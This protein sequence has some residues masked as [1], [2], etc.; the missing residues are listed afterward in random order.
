MGWS[1]DNWFI[2]CLLLECV[3]RYET[4]KCM[5]TRNAPCISFNHSLNPCHKLWN[6][7]KYCTLSCLERLFVGESELLR[8]EDDN[9]T[10]KKPHKIH[11]QHPK[12]PK[13]TTPKP[14]RPNGPFFPSF[15]FPPNTSSLPYYH[16][17]SCTHPAASPRRQSQKRLVVL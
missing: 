9:N 3:H 11:R 2:L 14:R 4:F 15:L 5:Y 10:H 13:K 16:C 8:K 17:P 6:S 7:C 1:S 12:H